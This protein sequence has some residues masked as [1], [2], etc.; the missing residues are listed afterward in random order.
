VHLPVDIEH[1]LVEMHA[2][3]LFDRDDIEEHVHHKC[4]FGAYGDNEKTKRA[5]ATGP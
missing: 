4:L 1:K 2:H 5:S 3:F